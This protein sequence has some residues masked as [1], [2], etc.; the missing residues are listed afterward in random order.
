MTLISIWI[1]LIITGSHEGGSDEVCVTF[2]SI[3]KL[4]PALHRMY[5]NSPFIRSVC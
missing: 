1:E 4:Q 3:T 2:V 5:N